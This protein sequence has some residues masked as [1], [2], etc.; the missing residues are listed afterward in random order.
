MRRVLELLEFRW[1]MSRVRSRHVSP[2]RLD[3]L[4]GA[5]ELRCWMVH[6]GQDH[7]AS[8]ETHKGGD[9]LRTGVSFL[10]PVVRKGAI[11]PQNGLLLKTESVILPQEKRQ[12]T[13]R[14]DGFG[15]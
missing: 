12:K 11:F 6:P 13:P 7:A 2:R 14:L 8:H 1:P 15:L 10:P 5:P 4:A 9:G 3:L